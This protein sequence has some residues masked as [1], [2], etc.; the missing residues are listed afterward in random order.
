M[1]VS[2][3]GV[4]GPRNIDATLIYLNALKK[5]H[6]LKRNKQQAVGVLHSDSQ[7]VWRPAA[8]IGE[9]LEK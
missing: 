4:N 7:F 5:F 9:S 1:S 3:I 8:A 6:Y 2:D